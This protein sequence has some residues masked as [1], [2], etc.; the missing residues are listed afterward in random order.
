ME[1]NICNICGGGYVYKNG[2]WI[3]SCCDNVRQDEITNEEVILLANASTRLRMADFDGAEE[4]YNDFVKKY[5]K[6]AEGY[7][8]LLLSKYGIKYEDDFD[9]FV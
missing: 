1:K 5:P 7:W 4:L 3:C 8:G 6:N 9:G 2:K